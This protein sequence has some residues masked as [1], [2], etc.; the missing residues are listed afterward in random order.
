M[1]VSAE[2]VVGNSWMSMLTFV[3]ARIA[4]TISFARAFMV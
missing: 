2:L 3:S 4:S 1:S